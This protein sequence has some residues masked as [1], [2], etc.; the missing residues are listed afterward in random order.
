MSNGSMAAVRKMT[1][2]QLVARIRAG[3]NEADNMLQLYKQ[4]KGF[5]YKM[6]M[7]YSEHAEIDDLMQEGYIGL[8]EAVRHYDA[9]QG[10][11]FLSYAA[12]W[13][14][15]CM[16]RYL[17]N[18]GSVV[19]IP[20]HAKEWMFKYKRIYGE[21]LK[22]Y[23]KE[24]TDREMRA[25]LGVSQEKLEDIR[26]ALVMDNTRSLSEPIGDDDITLEDTVSSADNFEDD[27]MRDLDH[28]RMAK[29]L[30]DVVDALP[31]KQCYAIRKKYQE[32]M[33]LEAIGKSI[34]VSAERMRQEQYKGLRALR[35]P[36]KCNEIFRVYHE[37]YL[38]PAP[39]YHVGVERFNRTWTSSVEAQAIRECRCVCDE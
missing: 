1:N 25:F 29:A 12:F 18:C 27:L 2:E 21:Y 36:R 31:D 13:I 24:P 32:G 30:W 15:Q 6:A 33:T 23:G 22:W 4:N 11:T 26:K 9:D 19:R 10:T 37:E 28:E 5:I 16:M 14:K 20:S 34:G 39:I 38:S 3:E 35:S 7:K 17:E 8:C